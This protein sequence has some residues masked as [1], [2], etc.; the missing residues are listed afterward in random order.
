[1]IPSCPFSAIT[2]ANYSSGA[3]LLCR[4]SSAFFSVCGSAIP[5]LGAVA[6]PPA[7]REKH[8]KESTITQSMSPNTHSAPRMEF[9][10]MNVK[11]MS[12]H[13]KFQ[14][15]GRLASIS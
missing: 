2:Y 6:Q 9:E 3:Y 7:A 13:D 12:A 4:K 5:S 11:P 15:K 1:M 10:G 14:D 8:E